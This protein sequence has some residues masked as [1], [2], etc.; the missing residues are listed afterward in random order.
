MQGPRSLS[1]GQ[2]GIMSYRNGGGVQVGQPRMGQQPMGQQPMG[3]PTGTMGNLY[4]PN[5]GPI[6]AP[7]INLPGNPDIQSALRSYGGAPTGP[8]NPNDAAVHSA[9]MSGQGG[10]GMYDPRMQGY[11]GRGGGS[12]GNIGTLMGTNASGMGVGAIRPPSRMG[13]RDYR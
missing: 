3:T 4:S 10:E 11:Q 2:A 1:P 5:L 7:K 13:V 12:F 6:A 8:D 9:Q